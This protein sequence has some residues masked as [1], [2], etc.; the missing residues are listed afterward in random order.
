MSKHYLIFV[1]GI[2]ERQPQPSKKSHEETDNATFKNYSILWNNLA[3]ASAQSGCDFKEQFTPIY[4]D[5]HTEQ[6]HKAEATIYNAAFPDLAQRHFSLLRPMQNFAT[7]FL[8]DVIAYVSKDV[9]VIRRTVWKQIWDQLK[10]P[11][12]EEGATYSIV[13]HSLGTV[14]TFDYLYHLLKLDELFVKE[15]NPEMEVS[16]SDRALLRERF[17]HFFTMGSPIGLFM[18]RE[19]QLWAEGEPFKSIYNPIRGHGCTWLNF[20]D[21]KDLIAYPLKDIFNVNCAGNHQCLPEDIP[22]W[23]GWTPAGAHNHY[24]KNKDVAARMAQALTRYPLTSSDDRD[25]VVAWAHS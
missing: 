13:A 11:L 2:G 19:G 12:R 23:T 1:H 4:T 20:F 24:W 14:I 21:N 17:R 18:L 7:F 16:E 15:L 25:K 22:V 5:W 10:Q 9:N 8:G 6:I 3:Q